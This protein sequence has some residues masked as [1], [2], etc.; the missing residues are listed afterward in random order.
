MLSHL[1]FPQLLSTEINGK[2]CSKVGFSGHPRHETSTLRHVYFYILVIQHD[3]PGYQ[4]LVRCFFTNSY[5]S[6]GLIV[7]QEH[8]GFRIDI[9]DL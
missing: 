2:H 5:L 9:L 3:Y 4:K 1:L 8:I 6:I 7:N